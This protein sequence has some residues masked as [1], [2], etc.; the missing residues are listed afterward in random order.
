M[1]DALPEPALLAGIPERLH[2]DW[3]SGQVERSGV[4][5]RDVVT[6]R[7]RGHYQ[8]SAEM[9]R[10]AA[11]AAASGAPASSVLGLSGQSLQ[12]LGAVGSAASVLNLAVTV[13]GFALVL[14]RLGK[15]DGKVDAVLDKLSEIQTRLDRRYKVGA[16][17][18]ARRSEEAFQA[19]A[20][21]QRRVWGEAE[22]TFDEALTH[23]F[24]DVIG[25]SLVAADA[26]G[27]GG[28]VA[29]YERLPLQE[30]LALLDWLTF[31]G[32]GRIE[33]LYLL[34]E[35]ARAAEFAGTLG[36]WLGRFEVRPDAYVDHRLG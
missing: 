2:A 3:A 28:P 36:G 29:L 31:C 32:R 22:A 16:I 24:H 33:A 23:F 19:S 20:G 35:P 10:Q 4:L 34:G 14:N 30:S 8:P 11:E 9:V 27:G 5:L 12:M 7:I 17:T 21:E 13:G 1:T 18:A 6:K 15:L 25:D 26:D